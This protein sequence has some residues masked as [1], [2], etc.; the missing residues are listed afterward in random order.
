MLAET[1]PAPVAAGDEPGVDEHP[2]AG[3]VRRGLIGLDHD[4]RGVAVGDVPLSHELEQAP[5][6]SRQEIQF[7]RSKGATTRFLGGGL[8]A[9][10]WRRRHG[11]RRTF[12]APPTGHPAHESQGDDEEPD[13]RCVGR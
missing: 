7:V 5:I 8:A 3:E 1:R 2:V 10:L 6:G 13:P 12:G 9:T 4:H 11:G